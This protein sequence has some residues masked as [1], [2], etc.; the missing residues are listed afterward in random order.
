MYNLLI[1]QVQTEGG[2]YKMDKL[3]KQINVLHV[4]VS[5]DGSMVLVY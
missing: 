5:H 1:Y 2:S 3:M 4:F